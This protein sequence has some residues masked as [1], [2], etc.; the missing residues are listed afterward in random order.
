MPESIE[1]VQAIQASRKQLWAALTEPAH[2][3]GWQADNA[4]G[5]LRTQSLRLGWPTL[6]VETELRVVE[7]EN[8]AR[9]VLSSGRS[10]VAFTLESERLRLTHD[11]LQGRDEVEGVRSSWQVALSLLDH[12]LKHHFAESRTVHWAI[13][14]AEVSAEA[15]HVFFTDPQALNAW[16]TQATQ[17][18]GAAGS[19]CSMRLKSGDQLHGMV[20]ANTAN[21]DVA[22]TWREREDSVLVFRTLPSPFVAGERILALSWSHWNCSGDDEP[23]QRHFVSAMSTLK[24]TLTRRGTA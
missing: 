18:I 7:V 2:L 4:A 12:Y 23:M 22:I 10:V 13:T 11:G 5:S 20:L 1:V 15:A 16:L 9:L 21:R 24:Q 3:A 8:E 17:G 6:G 14:P 19:E